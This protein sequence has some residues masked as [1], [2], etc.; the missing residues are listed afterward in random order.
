M[1]SLLI[2]R[3]IEKKHGPISSEDIVQWVREGREERADRILKA[4]T[5][6]K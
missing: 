6:K 1:S 5:R 3:E 2:G 4:A